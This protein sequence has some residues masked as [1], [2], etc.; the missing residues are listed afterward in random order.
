MKPY[1]PH[2]MLLYCVLALDTLFL[3]NAIGWRIVLS[4]VSPVGQFIHFLTCNRPAPRPTPDAC[5][6]RYNFMHLS[7]SVAVLFFIV[8]SNS[9][10][11]LTLILQMSAGVEAC[12]LLTLPVSIFLRYFIMPK[13]D[14]SSF[15]DFE[16]GIPLRVLLHLV[17]VLLQYHIINMHDFMQHCKLH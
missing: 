9:H 4:G 7:I 14:C 3:L 17:C 15:L 10:S 12:I 1:A 16:G 6:L 5:I 2:C 13:N 8:L 11:M